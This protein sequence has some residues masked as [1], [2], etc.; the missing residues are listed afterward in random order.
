MK[1]KL[2]KLFAYVSN[3]TERQEFWF[4]AVVLVILSLIL[5]V[6]MNVSWSELPSDVAAGRIAVQDIRA[7]K[8]YVIYDAEETDARR[9]AAMAAVLPVFDWDEDLNKEKV[10]E[11]PADLDPWRE[12]GVMVR[13]VKNPEKPRVLLKE[14]GSVLSLDEAKAK[15]E[16][17]LNHPDLLP[18]SE[19]KASLFFNDTET[20]ALREKAAAEIEPVTI[21]V[22]AGQSIVRSGDP[23][24]ERSVKIIEGI[25]KEKQKTY[26]RTRLLGTFLFVSLFL[27]VFFYV[28]QGSFRRLKMAPKDLVF[29]GCLLI[30][31]VCV[32][33]LSLFVFGAVKGLLPFHFEVPLSS[34]YGLIPVA[35]VTMMVR[36]VLPFPIAI[37]FVPVSAVMAGFIVHGDLNFT[38]F[39][40]VSCALGL[41][42]MAR[43]RT[44]GQ[45]LK[46][47][48]QLG[49]IQ[50][51]LAGIFDMINVTTLQG[52][53]GWED[54]LVR[55][56]FAFLGG[57]MNA[58]AVLILMPVFEA[59]FNYLTPIKL[60]EFGSLNHPLLREMIVRAPGT[61]HHSH[62]V[63]TL[64]E[65]ACEAIGADSLFARVASYFHDIGKMVKAPYFIENQ[66]AAGSE[67]KHS[68]LS[69]SMSAL[70]ISS[71]VKDGMELARQH[72]LPQKIVDIIPQHQGTKLITYFYNKAKEREDPD[73]H[74]V[75]ERDYRYPGP[76]PQTREAGVI[77]LADTT[78][79]ATRALKDRSP[80]RLEDVVRNM[81]NKNFID[82]Q[83]DECELTLKDLH[84]IANSFLRVLMGIYHQRVEYPPDEADK[85]AQTD[86]N[87]HSQPKPLRED[88]LKEAQKLPPKS[89]PRI[90]GTRPD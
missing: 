43:V 22:K 82:G 23:F 87:K 42:L 9:Q 11:D 67:D 24:D 70:I 19:P 20:R 83:L 57:V 27:I 54:A 55:V 69:P 58:L 81:I 6:L 71:H 18:E 73:M 78:E 88:S 59:A 16:K 34:F 47:G 62:M 17:D 46:T 45:I 1:R 21:A 74:V 76:K 15:A 38:I 41:H 40:L 53:A 3:L 50:A 56:I 63:G 51:L 36:L 61:Y 66:S 79:A 13:S 64:A 33:R 12:R 10:V 52:S 75:S 29:L 2:E 8:D 7:D 85:A 68:Q 44:R 35:F 49:A 89:I 31:L 4:H 37:L 30:L 5:S 14:L 77:L 39:Q 28:L 60:L 80:A 48:F 26:G 84:T 25:R 72:N 90:G 65:S 86:A 32:E